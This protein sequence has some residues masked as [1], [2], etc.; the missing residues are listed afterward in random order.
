MSK[1]FRF[2]LQ[3]YAPGSAKDWR[4]LARKAESMGFSSFHLADHVI[5]PDRKSVV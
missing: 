5:G 4:D 1:P 2:G 3:A